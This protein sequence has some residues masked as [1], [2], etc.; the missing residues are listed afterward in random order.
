MQQH[1]NVEYGLS[2]IRNI[3]PTTD[4]PLWHVEEAWKYEINAS[5]SGTFFIRDCIEKKLSYKVSYFKVC[6]KMNKYYSGAWKINLQMKCGCINIVKVFFKFLVTLIDQK[7]LRSFTQKYPA[8][9]EQILIV[10]KTCKKQWKLKQPQKWWILASKYNQEILARFKTLR[11][12]W[13]HFEAKMI[14]RF[15]MVAQQVAYFA[16]QWCIMS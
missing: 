11:T 13:E 16:A 15:Q 14:Y 2:N 9:A 8:N 3:V 5:V 6:F 1:D 10:Q 7:E 4:H 12:V